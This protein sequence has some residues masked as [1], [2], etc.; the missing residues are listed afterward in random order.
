MWREKNPRGVSPLR[1]IQILYYVPMGLLEMLL[2]L[3]ATGTGDLQGTVLKI[4]KYTSH[5]NYV[6]K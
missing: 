5:I 1:S 4:L 2:S 3:Y 6:N